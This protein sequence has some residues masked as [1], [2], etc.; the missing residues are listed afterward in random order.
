MIVILH[1]DNG[2]PEK[3]VVFDSNNNPMPYLKKHL[4][5]W[6]IYDEQFQK[7]LASCETVED[8]QT[9]IEEEAIYTLQVYTV[10]EMNPSIPAKDVNEMSDEE[11]MNAIGEAYDC[12]AWSHVGVFEDILLANGASEDDSDAERGFFS[13]MSSSQLRTCYS[14]IQNYLKQHYE[15]RGWEDCPLALIELFNL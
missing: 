2:T 1:C 13:T 8:I 14:S 7:D 4:K 15:S 10:D 9:L 3:V 5:S 6:D 12:L 11:L